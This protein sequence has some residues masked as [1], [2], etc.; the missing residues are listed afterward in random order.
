MDCRSSGVRRCGTS[1]LRVPG[2]VSSSAGSFRVRLVSRLRLSTGV[3]VEAGFVNSSSKEAF[4]SAL[5]AT[6]TPLLMSSG[7]ISPRVR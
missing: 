4:L 3:L 6:M 7:V 2:R 5:E 1:T